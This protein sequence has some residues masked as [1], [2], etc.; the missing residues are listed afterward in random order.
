[1]YTPQSVVLQF[2][3]T[4]P[5]IRAAGGRKRTGGVD[6]SFVPPGMRIHDLMLKSTVYYHRAS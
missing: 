4:H 6:T 2:P 3:P 1:V 5:G